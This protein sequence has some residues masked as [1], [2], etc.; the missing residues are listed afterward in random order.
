MK[1]R[2][3]EDIVIIENGSVTFYFETTDENEYNV[4]FIVNGSINAQQLSRKAKLEAIKAVKECWEFRYELL[5]ELSPTKFTMEVYGCDQA[6]AK[7]QNAYAKEGFKYN[8][9]N[10]NYEVTLTM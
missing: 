8:A 6:E 9:D 1:F 2:F 4:H 5:S 7:R 3:E 10:D